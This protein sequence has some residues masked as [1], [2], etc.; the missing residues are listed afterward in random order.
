MTDAPP[1]DRNDEE[2][3]ALAKNLAISIIEALPPDLTGADALS[4]FASAA[5]VVIASIAEATG[6]G[7]DGARKAVQMWTQALSAFVDDL[8][9]CKQAALSPL[10][11]H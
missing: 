1:N 9:A 6:A 5:S 11:H 4:I 3:N 2:L 8:Y 10:H 7:E